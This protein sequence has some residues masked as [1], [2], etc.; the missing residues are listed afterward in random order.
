M[1]RIAWTLALTCLLSLLGLPKTS[2]ALPPQAA[3]HNNCASAT[4]GGLGGWAV[5]NVCSASIDLGLAWRVHGSNDSWN[6]RLVRNLN[7]RFQ[8]AT[9]NCA[10]CVLDIELRAFLTSDR[11]SD[12]ELEPNPAR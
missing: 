11:V 9:P 8:V 5:K 7:P 1:K 4:Q 3:E 10:G 6:S 2:T 12:S